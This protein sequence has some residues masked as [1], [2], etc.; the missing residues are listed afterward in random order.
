M[1]P[2]EQDLETLILRT[3]TTL[4]KD[5]TVRMSID[6]LRQVTPTPKTLAGAP[7][8]TNASFV[9]SQMFKRICEENSK[10]RHFVGLPVAPGFTRISV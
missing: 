1:T 10:I 6:N 9:Y 4:R 7:T 8:G 2:F 5:G 3:I